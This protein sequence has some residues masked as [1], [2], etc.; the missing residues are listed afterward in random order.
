MHRQVKAVSQEELPLVSALTKMSTVTSQ[1]Y[2]YIRFQQGNKLML[3][4]AKLIKLT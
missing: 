3:Y 2:T 1:M 4:E